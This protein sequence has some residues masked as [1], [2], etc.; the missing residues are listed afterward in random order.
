MSPGMSI[1]AESDHV[2]V[3]QSILCAH[4]FAAALADRFEC[5]L[6]P[7]RCR[8]SPRLEARPEHAVGE[9]M[10]TCLVLLCQQ[11]ICAEAIPGSIE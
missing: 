8:T 2:H 11:I 9:F 4:A 3:Y 1:S 7:R 5:P 6:M 10:E